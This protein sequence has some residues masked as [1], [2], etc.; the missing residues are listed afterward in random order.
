VRAQRCAELGAP[1]PG[2]PTV[3]VNEDPFAPVLHA[4]ARRLDIGFPPAEHVAWA[5]AS[6]DVLEA[7]AGLATLQRRA[8]EAAATLAAELAGRGRRVAPRGDSTLVSF[9]VE[10]DPK[11]TVVRLREEGLILRDLPGTPYVRVS[12][13]GW[14]SEQDLER[15]LALVA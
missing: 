6:L 13:G 9:E 7:G 5:L 8:I 11:E 3:A 12:V 10:G 14:T 2:Y 1:W 4:D 15:L